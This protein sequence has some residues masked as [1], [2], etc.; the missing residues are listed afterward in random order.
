MANKVQS[1]ESDIGAKVAENANLTDKVQ[2][3]ERNLV[4]KIAENE[5]LES[6]NNYW[7]EGYDVLAEAFL[8]MNRYHDLSKHIIRRTLETESRILNMTTEELEKLVKFA[9]YYDATLYPIVKGVED[10]CSSAPPL[11]LPF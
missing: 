9:E 3:L 6:T 10:L 7:V 4:E 2:G 5:I 8:N 11:P 1:L